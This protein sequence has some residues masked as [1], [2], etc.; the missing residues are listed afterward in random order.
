MSR[1][2]IRPGSVTDAGVS[3]N[4]AAWFKARW[5]RVSIV[6]LLELMQRVAQMAL[7]PRGVLPNQTQN[8]DADRADGP[9]TPGPLGSTGT[10][11]PLLDEVT[12]PTQH[13]VRPDQHPQPAQDIPRQ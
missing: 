13:S 9:R 11:M 2:E 3:R 4:G 5:G 7:V 1:R 10:G 12:M 6:V 8:E